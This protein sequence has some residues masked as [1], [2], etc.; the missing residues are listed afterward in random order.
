MPA[1]KDDSIHKLDHLLLT[2]MMDG[3]IEIYQDIY[4]IRLA[5]DKVI[6]A[7]KNVILDS[8]KQPLKLQKKDA[9][10]LSMGLAYL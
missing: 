2:P 1:F 3:F 9:T 8:T 6:D 10:Q 4:G 7:C 5:L